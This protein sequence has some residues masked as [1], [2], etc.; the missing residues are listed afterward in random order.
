MT[1]QLTP[2][3]K[4]KLEDIT[5]L[6]PWVTQIQADLDL[7]SDGEEIIRVKVGLLPTLTIEKPS[8]ELGQRLNKITTAIRIYQGNH[9]PLPFAISFFQEETP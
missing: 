3:T 9:I 5:G 2:E 8:L 6:D 7:D 4:A 1:F